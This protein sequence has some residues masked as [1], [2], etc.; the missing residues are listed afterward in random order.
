MSKK[1]KA[2]RAEDRRRER[3]TMGSLYLA[4]NDALTAGSLIDG[5]RMYA[6]SADAINAKL[7]RCVFPI[8]QLL[9]TSIELSLKAF[10]RHH[11][12]TEDELQKLGHNLLLT[13]QC[14]ASRGLL[15]TGSRMLV[16]ILPRLVDSLL[17]LPRSRTLGCS[18]LQ[19]TS[20][21]TP[22]G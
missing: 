2:K 16:L 7:P 15:D 1:A 22:W 17:T 21:R 3:R 13:F 6:A 20:S 19:G 10:L 8:S 4:S 5:A 12:A 11:G 14:A 9:C 18:S